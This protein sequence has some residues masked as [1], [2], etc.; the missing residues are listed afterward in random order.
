MHAHVCDMSVFFVFFLL[1]TFF[2]TQPKITH[3][4]ERERGH[5]TITCLFALFFCVSTGAAQIVYRS[6]ASN[7][8]PLW[9]WVFWLGV[10]GAEWCGIGAYCLAADCCTLHTHTQLDCC[11]MLAPARVCGLPHLT[12]DAFPIQQTNT[13][14][15]SLT[16]ATCCAIWKISQNIVG[17][18]WWWWC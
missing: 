7:T 8:L 11:N 13:H 16:A 18:G 6:F 3:E 1:S 10:W 15:A 14:A 17:S 5:I 9:V 4:H 12:C 2:R